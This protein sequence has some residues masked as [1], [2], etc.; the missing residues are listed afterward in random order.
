MPIT[1]V[2]EPALEACAA[3]S[4]L[5]I[6]SMFDS[7]VNLRAG[8]RLVACTAHAL[9]APH[10]I[11]MSTADLL[12]LHNH[13]RRRLTEPLRWDSTGRRITDAAGRLTIVA[14]PNLTVFDPL[15]PISHPDRWGRTVIDLLDYLTRSK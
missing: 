1:R 4:N 7:A 8:P 2:G 14:A 3:S 11:E 13:G 9:S 10:G 15:L 6:H 12:R 5:T